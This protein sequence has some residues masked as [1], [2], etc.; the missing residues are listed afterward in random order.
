MIQRGDIGQV[1][2]VRVWN[3]ANQTPDGIGRKSAQQPPEWLDW[4]MYLSP[5]PKVPF[6]PNRFLGSFRYFWDCSGGY[7]TDFGNHRLDTMQQVMGVTAPKVI[8]AT[9][10]KYILEDDRET[11]PH[12]LTVTDEYDGF[13][14]TYEGSN[15]NGYGMDGR[16]PG[17][18]SYNA[19]GGWDQP[20]GMAFYGTE[21][22]LIAERIGWE[23]FPEPRA[24]KVKRM[25]EK[26]EEPTKAHTINFVECLRSRKA[27]NADIE[28]PIAAHQSHC[29]ATSPM[30]TGKSCTGTRRRTISQC[31]G[32]LGDADPRF[33]QALGPDSYLGNRGFFTLRIAPVW[34]CA[35]VRHQR[36]IERMHLLHLVLHD[37]RQFL[38]LIRRSLEYQLV[39]HLQQHR[40][41]HPAGPQ[42]LVDPHHREL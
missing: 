25:W 28:L 5:S 18:R 31:S 11:R 35:N 3:Y 4:D 16:T 17:H 15:L 36:H 6:N 19:C 41:L 37:L 1:K 32:R 23:I 24:T 34:P 27:P 10:G 14:A 39:M 29:S 8:S 22:T 2:F 21:A 9:G 40:T 20:N 26:V 42:P 12:F 38:H 33:P 30:K 13:I 7:I